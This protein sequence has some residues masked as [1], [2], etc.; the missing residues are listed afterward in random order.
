MD[1][2]KPDIPADFTELYRKANL[3]LARE[4]SDSDLLDNSTEA[5]LKREIKL[6]QI[7]LELER[8]E[9][10]NRESELRIQNRLLE[11][12][13]AITQVGSVEMDV[14]TRQ[15]RWSLETYRIHD[16]SPEEFNPNLQDVLE[17]YTPE[18]RPI[19]AAA[20]KASLEEG[21]EFD[22]EV[23]K[24]TF[25]GRKISIRT[26]C[27]PTYENGKIVK[28]TGIFQD[29]TERKLKE[30]LIQE[31]EHLLSESQRIAHIGSWT[32]DLITRSVVWSDET[33]R[34]YG[35][36]RKHF[37]PTQTSFFNLIHP[38]DHPKMTEWRIQCV[39]DDTPRELEFRI[40]RS[41]GDIRFIN[42]RSNLERD[43]LG[44]PQRM[45]GTVQDITERKITELA[46]AHQSRILGMITEKVPLA[47][48][49]ET[50][51]QDIEY[52]N[53][54][55]KCTILLLDDYSQHLRHG[56]APSLPDFYIQAIDGTAIGL[57][58]GSCGTAAFTGERAIVEDINTHPWWVDY[59][60]LALS[61]GLESCWSQPILAYNGKVL[62]TFAIYHHK[63]TIPKPEDLHF[64]E[65]EAQLAA[66]AIEKHKNRTQLELAASVFTHAGE[67][68][69]ITDA[70]ANIVDVN[71]TF[72]KITGYSRA[73]VLGK[74]PRFLQ[75]GRHTP[76]FYRHLWSD[77]MNKGIWSGE[78]WNKRKNGEVFAEMQTIS[79]VMDNTGNPINFVSLFS[80]IT[81][82]K[83]HQQQL[84]YIAHYDALTRLPNRV[85]LADRLKQ[86]IA[87]CHRLN[88]SL[89]VLYIDLDGFK[90]INDTHGHDMGDQLL[91][92]VAARWTD[93]LREGD[94]LARI[95]GDEF[96]V[97]LVDLEDNRNYEII[98]QRLL[99]TAAE[100]ITINQQILR[101]S[102]SIG[103]TIYPQD[104]SDA[105][106][107]MRHADQA[108]YIAKQA[109]KNC[110]HL[111]DVAHDVAVK[112]HRESI[113]HIRQALDNREFVLYYQ[114]KVN[115]RTGE[116]IG[117]EALIRW[118]HPERGLLP[119]SA[120]LPIIED[121]HLSIDVGDW[122]INQALSQMSQWQQHGL[123]LA[124]SVNVGALQLQQGRFVDRLSQQLAAHPDVLANNLELEI[125]ETSALEDIADIAELMN[126]CLTLGVHFAVD[127]FGTG[128]SSLTYLKRLPAGLLKIDQSFVRDM[129]EDPDDL[130]IVK[131]VIG[132]ARAFHR[133]V[134]AEGVETIAHGQLLLAQGC[135][136]AQGYGI[137]RPM[138]ANDI[139]QWV[140]QWRPDKQWQINP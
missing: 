25:K 54:K 23:E 26:T 48:V 85:L 72:T 6:L 79:K 137:A 105:D 87:H 127:D 32:W 106:Q 28:F 24:Y 70:D 71:N 3:R 136:L 59:K 121:H 35:L 44:N 73:D 122:V 84:E 140:T 46:Q 130:A 94:T 82:L 14:A 52:I 108:M 53:P 68:I 102:A 124:V 92:T 33:Y 125:L 96:I 128:Y 86:A 13:Q 113:E 118:Q 34:I 27:I 55:A 98:L 135:Q 17:Y 10:R 100:T 40:L 18:S 116:V 42:G 12:A 7:A 77:L 19:I 51:A 89:A 120:F 39:N 47:D 1:T 2:F 30:K 76:E 117:V 50:M 5:A 83:E 138:P 115:M 111:F 29:I 93:A 41:D 15:L 11:T 123:T 36:S 101:V 110:F 67:G 75:S 37:N 38:D 69:M 4:Q 57:G 131:G 74:N 22:L 126:Q 104:S 114:P 21:K 49:L 63:P 9:L 60:E 95:G 81:P 129:L 64:I 80:D 99:D 66:V 139:P 20:I 56:A 65:T 58:V 16:T 45:V 107:L 8:D 78:I 88:S 103:V 91:V 109:G 133:K 97:L 62:G 132:L 90:S 61:A 112:T 119:P 134:I 31:K 43:K